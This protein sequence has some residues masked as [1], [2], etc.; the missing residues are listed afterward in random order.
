M[1]IAELENHL[2]IKE[3]VLAEFIIEISKGKKDSDEFKK[4]GTRV[5]QRIIQ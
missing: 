3:K 4:V 1:H 2:G 5:C